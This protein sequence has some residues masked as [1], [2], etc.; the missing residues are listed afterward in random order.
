[1]KQAGCRRGQKTEVE[2]VRAE[3][4][5][6][7]ITQHPRAAGD[8]DQRAVIGPITLRVHVRQIV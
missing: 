6:T 2:D 1:M 7:G 4:T 3:G 5:R 8:L